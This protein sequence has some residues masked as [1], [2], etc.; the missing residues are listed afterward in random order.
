M[1]SAGHTLVD[2][3]GTFT[4]VVRIDA[5]GRVT[6]DKIPSDRAVIGEL[7]R[8]DGPTS[9]RFGTTVATNAL[10]ERT[11]VPTLALVTVGLEGL[12][13]IS[14]M[15]RPDLFDPDVF[16]DPP[17][18]E[19]VVGVP[20]RIDA[21]GRE[22]EALSF[23]DP[24]V[25]EGVS[26]VAIALV[27]SHRN[28]DHEQQLADWVRQHAP[29]VFVAL[30]HVASPERGVL[31]RLETAL[32]HAA[33]TPVLR[34]ALDRDRIPDDALAMR[35]D[36]SLCPAAQLEAPDAVLSGPAGGVLA[37]QAIAR[38]AGFD[39]A[40]GLDMGGTSTDVCRLGSGVGGASADGLPRRTGRVEV[41]GVHLQ[42]PILSV[43]TIAAGGGSICWFDGTR[44]GVGPRSAGADPGP[45][46]Y[47]RGGPPTLTDAALAT[48]LVDPARFD[49]PLD[50]DAVSLPDEPELFLR[51]AREQMAAAVRRLALSDG[52]DLA[53]HAL[54]AF[55]GAAGQHAAGVAR[56]LGIETVLI[57]PA[58]SVLS[59]WGQ[60]L[61]RRES[62]AVVDLHVPLADEQAVS[63][64]RD[65]VLGRLQAEGDVTTEVV[66]RYAGTDGV[67]RLPWSDAA[68]VREQFVEAHQSRFGF[69]RDA[70]LQITAV[71]V[72]VSGDALATADA[73]PEPEPIDLDTVDTADLDDGGRV[74]HLP[75][76]S[77]WVP[78][79]WE[80][81]TERGVVRLDRRP[82]SVEQPEVSESTVRTPAGVALWSAR[83]MAVAE[84]GGAVLQRV[85]RSVN[86]RERHDFSCAVFD[87]DGLLVAN[88]P[89]IPVHLGAMGVTV[90]DLVRQRSP[91]VGSHWLCNAPY[92][93][94]SHLP[95][96]TVVSVAQLGDRRVYVASRA[97]H[98]D[99]G[100]TTPG[101][102]PPDSTRLAD[103]GVVFE[104]VQVFEDG[105]G[106]DVA[107]SR[108]PDT[109]V[110]DLAA[111]VA[112]NRTMLAGLSDLASAEGPAAV[113]A[114][115]GHVLDASEE[116]AGRVIADMPARTGPVEDVLDS[117]LGDVSLR[118]TTRVEDGILHVDFAGTGGPHA[119]N[120]NT[121][122]A[123]VRAAV[124]YA[125]RVLLA[126][127]LPL[128]EGVLRRVRIHT[129][130]PSVLAP[131]REAAVAGGNVETS[132]R[133]ADLL[134]RAMGRAAA[135]AG[136][137]NNL[138][139]G[140]DG[141]SYYETLGGGQGGTD[142]GRGASGRQLHMTNT[143][144]TDPEVLEHRVP[145][146][147]R[148]FQ[149]REGSGGAGEHPGGDGLI[150]ELE[151]LEP[152]TAAL[153]GTRRASGAQGRGGSAG[154]PAEDVVIRGG[155]EAA[156]DGR[157]TQLE[158]GDR[159]RICTPGGGGFGT[160]S[161]STSTGR[162]GRSEP[163]C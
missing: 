59:A 80:A 116:L 7:A 97:H 18:C 47:G 12:P 46:C 138:T 127:D 73:M 84:Q 6:L 61:A 92:A 107:G 147:V 86:V 83:F 19:R 44:L 131:S 110:A 60:A 135:S 30:G 57:H 56:I 72:R 134:L 104:H 81:R 70:P 91:E 71:H 158:V 85:A 22:V 136:T 150:R 50:P 100:G 9:L 64:A 14:D 94:G 132:M 63:D 130:S 119:G 117:P 93:G 151:V 38:R 160:T 129:P 115:M 142:R 99:V 48:G 143:K 103:E 67:I 33:I 69:V 40:V 161:T 62:S 11:G 36:G 39:H 8:A 65:A 54:V 152:C 87:A 4:D 122:P 141:W 21:G 113:H 79:D 106:P 153:L 111:Q 118:M 148:R 2:R 42:R 140:G 32:V 112:A 82:E 98:A 5:V 75:T 145:L 28:P 49:P 137:M 105:S 1:S 35:S 163:S 133:I 27:N 66:V 77:I 51:L 76:T 78:A 45:Q 114:W 26:A 34:A 108:Q 74:L 88:A 125:V 149:I 159:V 13:R 96:L 17:L 102:M 53:D 25:L 139:L 124:L 128:N 52:A 156:W 90:R 95:D 23:P 154:L 10:L 155:V 41:A 101:S 123:V 144:A 24:A 146:R 109:V 120:L 31:A 58:A 89:H 157:P 20:G 29:G 3:G 16:R 43:D 68:S 37:V 126:T 15:T 121:P 55:G 162:P